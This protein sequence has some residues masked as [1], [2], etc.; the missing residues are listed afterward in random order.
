MRNH[1]KILQHDVLLGRDN[2]LAALVARVSA[3][4]RGDTGCAILTAPSGFGKSVLLDS[5]LRTP[6]CW[7][8]T[9]LR[10]HC[11]EAAGGAGAYS[12]LRALFAAT[13]TPATHREETDG[14]AGHPAEF[15]PGPGGTQRFSLPTAYPVFR[16]LHRHALRLMAHRP[17]ILA[18]DDAHDCDEHSL[19]WLDF[20]LRRAAGHPC[21][22]S[23]HGVPRPVCEPPR[24]G[25]ASL[26]NPRCPSCTSAL[27]V[28]TPSAAWP[29][30]SSGHRCT[31][32]W[33]GTWPR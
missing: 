18:L 14:G 26:R 24:P 10:G 9:V 16:R 29:S 28:P 31:P 5:L 20:I 11:G 22:S 8:M 21:W 6:G 27:S 17:L 13:G 30:R 4:R 2:E 7:G 19:R 23:S 3:A 25:P 32:D 12:G 33:P 1:G 15:L